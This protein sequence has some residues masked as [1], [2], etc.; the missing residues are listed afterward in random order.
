MFWSHKQSTA[1]HIVSA[2]F[3]C[4]TSKPYPTLLATTHSVTAWPCAPATG[5]VATANTI[6]RM[7]SQLP[8]IGWPIRIMI[9]DLHTLQNRFYFHSS[10]IASLH[11]SIP[12]LHRCGLLL[13]QGCFHECP[14]RSACGATRCKRGRCKTTRTFV[15]DAIS[16]LRHP[17]LPI[18]SVAN[19]A[20]VNIGRARV[21]NNACCDSDGV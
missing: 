14:E 6:S 5:H 20:E 3:P 8:Q 21:C 2:Q 9:Y 7:L 11:T 10:T 15:R 17:A 12:L 13:G 19:I 4:T 16:R 18:K 1:D